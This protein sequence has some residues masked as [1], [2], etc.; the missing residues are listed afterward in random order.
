MRWRFPFEFHRQKF[1]VKL[2]A[3]TKSQGQSLGALLTCILKYFLMANLMLGY[4]EPE[5]WVGCMVFE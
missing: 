3:I 1:P 2:V 5:F 4:S